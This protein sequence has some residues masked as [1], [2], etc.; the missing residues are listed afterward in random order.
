[1]DVGSLSNPPECQGLA[2]FC[3]HMLFMGSKKYPEENYFASFISRNGGYT[4]ATT[5]DEATTYN[6]AVSAEKL[7]EALDIWAQVKI[8]FFRYNIRKI[9]LKSSKTK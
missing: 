9:T 6:F 5:R 1:M 3:E 4:N 8:H 2:H 7:K